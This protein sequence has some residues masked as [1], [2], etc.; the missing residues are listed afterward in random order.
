MKVARKRSKESQVVRVRV[1][2]TAMTYLMWDKLMGPDR[3]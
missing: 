1:F 3:D 2:E